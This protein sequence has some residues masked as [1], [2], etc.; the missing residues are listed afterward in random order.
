MKVTLRLEPW[1]CFLLQIMSSV[2]GLSLVEYIMS[3]CFIKDQ[4]G[5]VTV[6]GNLSRKLQPTLG[7]L[8]HLPMVTCTMV[9]AF[10]GLCVVRCVSSHSYLLD[11]LSLLTCILLMF[12]QA[13]C[14]SVGACGGSVMQYG[15][16]CGV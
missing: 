14:C 8:V 12:M 10:C 1:N 6:S 9:F 11:S 7:P 16:L 3:Q 5:M 4:I 13:S 2:S 15:H